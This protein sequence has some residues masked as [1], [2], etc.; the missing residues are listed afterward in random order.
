LMG[1]TVRLVDAVPVDIPAPD[2]YIA[3]Q[4]GTADGA[5]FARHAHP[6]VMSASPEDGFCHGSRACPLS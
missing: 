4:R 6:L 2:A 5:V 1:L 3:I